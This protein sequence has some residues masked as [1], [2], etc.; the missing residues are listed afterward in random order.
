MN[1]LVQTKASRSAPFSTIEAQFKPIGAP[2]RPLFREVQAVR[3]HE[4]HAFPESSTSRVL[5]LII[6]DDMLEF[7]AFIFCQG[8]FRQLGMTFEQFLLVA[9]AIK[10][11]DF[12]G[13]LADARTL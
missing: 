7:Y 9:S 11:A 2:S 6:R 10:P 12:P 8:G 13:T 1:A 5:P 3:A 4:L